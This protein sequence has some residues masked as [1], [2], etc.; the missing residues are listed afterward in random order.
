MRAEIK[1]GMRRDI[2]NQTKAEFL[3]SLKKINP[4]Y[5]LDRIGKA[6]DVAEKM[7]EGQFRKSGEPYLIHPIAVAQILAKLG[8]DEETVMGGLL[9][10]VIEDTTYTEEDMTRDFGED[11]TLLVVGVTKLASIK[12]ESKEE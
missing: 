4:N 3:D 11:V 8:M 1:A 10:D 6:F 2:V 12:F 9:H 7:H 5:D